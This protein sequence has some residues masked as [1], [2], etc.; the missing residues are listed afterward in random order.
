VPADLRAAAEAHANRNG[1]VYLKHLPAFARE[2]LWRRFEDALLPLD[3]AGKLGVVFFQFAPWVA[4]RDEAVEQIESIRRRLPQY[5]IAVEFRNRGWFADRQAEATLGLLRRQRLVHVAME[6]PQGFASRVLT[7]VDV[8]GPVAYVRFHG[9]NRAMWNART[10]TTGGRFDYWYERADLDEWV[11]RIQWRDSQSPETCVLF[12]L[13]NTN[14]D[15]QGPRNARVLA[16]ALA[17]AGSGERIARRDA[18]LAL[19]QQPPLVWP[20]PYPV[21]DL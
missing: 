14:N 19:A 15:D 18:V 6:E 1:R 13:S 16:V 2:V 5:T 8:T 11:P 7:V 17:D 4:P 20:L 12:N 3:S 9:R 21:Y 10:E